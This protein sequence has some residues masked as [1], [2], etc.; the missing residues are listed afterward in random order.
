RDGRPAPRRTA[1]MRNGWR[2]GWRRSP[3]RAGLVDHLLVV[4]EGRAGVLLQERD[5]VARGIADRD[6]RRV[7][8]R[9]GDG[10]RPIFPPPT[11]PTRIPMLWCAPWRTR[12]TRAQ[13]GRNHLAA[14]GRL[15]RGGSEL[16]A[17]R[18]S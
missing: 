1:R 15:T 10:D 3:R 14:Q 12:T 16:L 7:R 8:Q 5:D 18:V 6:H 9:V 2:S 4:G 17:S 13:D 11:L